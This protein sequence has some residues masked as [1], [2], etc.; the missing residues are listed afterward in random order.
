VKAIIIFEE[1]VWIILKVIIDRGF[2]KL[3]INNHRN[4]KKPKYGTVCGLLSPNTNE[5]THHLP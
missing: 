1:K 2:W 5:N 3:S 4:K